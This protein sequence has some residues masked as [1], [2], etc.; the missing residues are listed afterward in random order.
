MLLALPQGKGFY[1]AIVRDI[2]DPAVNITGCMNGDLSS[3]QVIVP[4]MTIAGEVRKTFA[5]NT[6]SPLLLPQF[7]T[8]GQWAQNFAA[9]DSPSV[10]S[11]SERQVLLYEALRN[12]EW[13]NEDI[14]WG[15]AAEMCALFDELTSA[16]LSLPESLDEMI[17]QLEK[18]YS[19]H[20]S[21]P[22]AFEARVVHEMWYAL[23]CSGQADKNS[24]YRMRLARLL[25]TAKASRDPTPAFVILDNAPQDA[26]SSAEL[27]LLK[28]YGEH[29]PLTVFHPQSRHACDS[30]LMKT[31]STAWPDK[32]DTP[33]F[34][35]AQSLTKEHSVSPLAGSL[36]LIPTEGQE[37]EAQTVVAQI[38]LWL[39]EGLR[40]I[41]LITAD[42][43]TARRVRALLERENILVNDET[44]WKLSTS[45]AA[46]MI[47]ALFEVASQVVYYRDLLD[48]LKSPFIF[49]SYTEA[50]RKAAVFLIESSIRRSSVHSGLEVIK[51]T[52]KTY[53]E[54]NEEIKNLALTFL[55]AISAA[56]TFLS[57]RTA[58]L[59]IWLNQLYHAFDAIGAIALL[60]QDIAGK[61]ILDWLTTRRFELQANRALFTLDALRDWFN[62]EMES[63]TFQDTRIQS[64][65]VMTPLNRAIMRHF[66][67]ALLMG[68]DAQHLTPSIG[69]AFFNHSVRRELG[70]SGIEDAQ[71]KLRKQ[72]E[73]LFSFVPRI[74]V[75]WQTMRH[76][77]ANLLA[78]D[79]DLLS[80]LH[81]AVWNDNLYH[82][83]LRARKE[84]PVDTLTAPPAVMPA[85][86]VAAPL[87]I[88]KRIPVSAYVSLV[89]CP[90]LFFAR[91]VLGL[92]EIDKVSETM[93]K[94][95]YGLLVHR[96]L[97]RFH[98]RCPVIVN[99]PA[100][101]A[102]DLLQTCVEEVFEKAIANNFLAIGWKARLTKHIDSYLAWQSRHEEAGWRW[103][104]SE[105]SASHTLT[106]ENETR[107][108]LYGRIDRI[109]LNATNGEALLL[110][111]K[112]QSLTSIRDR[113]NDDVQ[114]SAY[115]L[116]YGQAARAG[117]LALDNDPVRAVFKAEDGSE[118]MELARKE[119]E[120]LRDCFNA[121]HAGNPLPANGLDRGCTFCEMNGLCRV[122]HAH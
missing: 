27:D 107:F 117:Y 36:Q 66:E 18:A 102:H 51:K 77:E 47:D 19:L 14:L 1:T 10:I 70:L 12:K 122:S 108:E 80:T 39:N 26:L 41:V 91:Y 112:T 65:I 20:T 71:Q 68:G 79:L 81:Q 99:L 118:L 120:R 86:P 30:P 54:V 58:S 109:D 35:R 82:P 97:E 56:K 37:Q 16:S 22:L 32:T 121:I 76:G 85:A 98:Q 113:F 94:S 74:A 96:A 100:E 53:D 5:A 119:G 55:E 45:R 87:L 21:M 60:E 84:A 61:A 7:V 62:R 29:Q 104:Q 11:D 15:I 6:S 116:L 103:S 83:S 46:A 25:K 106:L 48:L 73:L 57:Y 28:Q 23:A 63:A 115:A 50:S 3:Y 72:L 92:S 34:V 2:L 75:T 89:N 13:F 42:R 4:C 9:L 64:S 31:L 52:V 33:L 69:T 114:L 38:G 44:G 40:H 88:P 101:K 49:S 95:D 67:A 24:L 111:Y 17:R 110:D 59:G 8:M 78:P 90:Y 93:V 43:L 105:V